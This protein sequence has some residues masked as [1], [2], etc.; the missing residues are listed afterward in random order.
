MKTVRSLLATSVLVLICS[1][2]VSAQLTTSDIAALQERG[3]K[4]GWTIQVH[5]NPATKQ[6]LSHLCGLV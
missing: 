4:E 3:K 6:K 1:S 2:Y 5:E